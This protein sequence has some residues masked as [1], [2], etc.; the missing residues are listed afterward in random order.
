MDNIFY[1]LADV[2]VAF[3]FPVLITAASL[4]LLSGDG[5]MLEALQPEV[6][7]TLALLG[8]YYRR[9]EFFDLPAW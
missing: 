8:A 3:A 9:I 2:R 4:Y 1:F 5:R 7:L 6:P